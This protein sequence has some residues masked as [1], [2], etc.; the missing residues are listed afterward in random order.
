MGS[1][2]SFSWLDGWAARHCPSQCLPRYLVSHSITRPRCEILGN[3]SV[4]SID[5][6]II[7]KRVKI[8]YD[9]TMSGVNISLCVGVWLSPTI[10]SKD[11]N[12][13][14]YVNFTYQICQLPP[15]YVGDDICQWL[16]NFNC[17]YLPG[18]FTY[19]WQI[20]NWVPVANVVEF[21]KICTFIEELIVAKAQ[22]LTSD[23]FPCDGLPICF[24]DFQMHE[25]IISNI[26]WRSSLCDRKLES[27]IP[28]YNQM[29]WI[30]PIGI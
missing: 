9:S 6:K 5:C 26:L 2:H 19:Q 23:S 13:G 21:C 15:W 14:V 8:K 30:N 16:P 7:W 29:K 1:L 25:N 28:N 4:Y 12:V 18:T 27:E 20:Y 17:Q 22:L 3:Q 10:I 24:E 11:I